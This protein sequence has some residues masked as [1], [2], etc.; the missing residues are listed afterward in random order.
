MQFDCIYLL[1]PLCVIFHFQILIADSN[2]ENATD[3][4]RSTDHKEV[5]SKKFSPNNAKNK[6]KVL[7][8]GT[9]SGIAISGIVFSI[10]IADQFYKDIDLSIKETTRGERLLSFDQSNTTRG[11]KHS[12]QHSCGPAALACS[13]AILDNATNDENIL[14]APAIQ[15]KLTQQERKI[16]QITKSESNQG[17]SLPSDMIAAFNHFKYNKDFTLKLY[18]EDNLITKLLRK[19]Y[20]HELNKLG[21]NIT[22]GAPPRIQDDELKIKV[23][24]MKR[25]GV[26][27]TGNL[28]YITE[29]A[30]GSIL[31]TGTGKNYRS[32]SD[33]SK[34]CREF[35]G[36]RFTTWNETGINFIIK[37]IK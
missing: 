15:A 22:W 20:P 24:M 35:G 26:V 37:K 27:P 6:K 17:D 36:G 1:L 2:I 34:A 9:I 13:M 32:L 8:V 11:F 3:E 16:Y 23:V 10:L 19:K 7:R 14:N 12:H 30:D 21:S 28:H 33:L 29:R 4:K 18:I 31:D 25:F 5:K